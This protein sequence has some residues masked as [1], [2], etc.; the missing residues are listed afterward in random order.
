MDPSA[1]LRRLL[2]AL[3]AP[4]VI[5]PIAICIV[6]AVGALLGTM[7]DAVGGRVL[8]WIALTGGILWGV[9]LV[10]LLLVQVL[11]TLNQRP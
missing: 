2:L 7:G 4:A 8:G 9:D 10:G 5:L 11:L 3:I 1:L 6:M